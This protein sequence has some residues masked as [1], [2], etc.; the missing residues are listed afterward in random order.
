MKNP[1]VAGALKL[2]GAGAL[3]LSRNAIHGQ[4]V[5]PTT[6][7]A[8]QGY[9]DG[10][11]NQLPFKFHHNRVASV[12]DYL[13]ICPW[14]ASRVARWNTNVSGPQIS[15]GG[16]TQLDPYNALQLIISGKVDFRWQVHSLPGG[17]GTSE[18]FPIS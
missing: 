7:E 17:Q 18:V 6:L 3:T 4:L 5:L 11:S 15:G 10:F 12:G 8:S 2:G 14:V 13:R 9:I 1:D 16:M